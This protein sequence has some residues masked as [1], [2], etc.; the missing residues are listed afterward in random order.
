MGR[1]HL[2]VQW[3]SPR[4]ESE[5]HNSIGRQHHARIA[6]TVHASR[7]YHV[8]AC[9]NGCSSGQFVP[10]QVAKSHDAPSLELLSIAKVPSAVHPFT[11]RCKAVA[12][13]FHVPVGECGPILDYICRSILPDIHCRTTYFAPS[14][15]RQTMTTGAGAGAA[16]DLHDVELQITDVPHAAV[17]YL[18][19]RTHAWTHARQG[20]WEPF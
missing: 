8:Y 4:L 1:L 3:C 20:A 10:V 17:R 14:P 12:S 11:G 6:S 2:A 19:T 5:S 15:Q 9:G 7:Y 18:S 13:L 16:I